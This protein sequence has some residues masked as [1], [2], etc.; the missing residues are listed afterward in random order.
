VVHDLSDGGLIAGAAEMALA[1]DVGVTLNATSHEHAH[2]YL[3]GEDQTRYL[4][5]TFD[6]DGLIA[7][8][9]AAGLHACVAGQAGGDAFASAAG[10]FSVPLGV[11]RDA[12]EGWM[13]G[14]MA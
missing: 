8:A 14:Y 6:P 7:K 2:F 5:A 3:F 1:A 9:Q 11:L 10:L 12:H 13:P 4:I